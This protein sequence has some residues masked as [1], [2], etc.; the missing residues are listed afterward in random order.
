MNSRYLS[1]LRSASCYPTFRAFVGFALVVGYILAASTVLVG[2]ASG[3]AE[4]ILIGLVAGVVVALLAKV[5]QE[6]ALMIADIADACIESASGRSTTSHSAPAAFASVRQASSASLE[7]EEQFAEAIRNSDVAAVRR[8]LEN[9]SVSANSRN[10]NGRGWLQYA[11]VTGSI[12]SA[13]VL[14]EHGA[15]PNEK[16]DLGRSAIEEAQLKK[17]DSFIALFTR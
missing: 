8:L 1:K 5:G 10:R 3:K 16:D 17:S 14:L 2:L 7:A 15:S 13:K 4:G 6:M 12:Q 9:H 11:T